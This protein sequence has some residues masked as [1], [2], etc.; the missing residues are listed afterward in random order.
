MANEQGEKLRAL[1][2]HAFQRFK[3]TNDYIAFQLDDYP[4][5]RDFAVERSGGSNNAVSADHRSLDHTCRKRRDQR[6]NGSSGEVDVTCLFL[7]LEQYLM[8][9]EV[10]RL[11]VRL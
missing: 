1:Q 4:A 10:H 9:F 8:L 6:D 2:R 11:Q 3:F 7:R 5:Q